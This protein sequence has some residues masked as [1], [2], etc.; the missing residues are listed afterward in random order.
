MFRTRNRDFDFMRSCMPN[1]F[2]SE[3]MFSTVFETDK[4]G[5]VQIYTHRSC[6]W[7]K[8]PL[9]SARKDVIMDD[10]NFVLRSTFTI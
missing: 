4:Q 6:N 8:T 5:W 3:I 10:R 7:R 2:S 9:F 1:V